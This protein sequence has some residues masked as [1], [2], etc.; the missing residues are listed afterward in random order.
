MAENV[1][2]MLAGLSGKW[3]YSIISNLSEH[4][5]LRFLELKA[6]VG[7]VSSKLLT[8]RLK[9]LRHA[10]FIERKTLGAS[11]SQGVIYNLSDKGI[12]LHVLFKTID[13]LMKDRKL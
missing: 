10:G 12:T 5:A 11:S 8:Q 1:E 2:K 9:D 13:D 3:T 6:V 7:K 4:S